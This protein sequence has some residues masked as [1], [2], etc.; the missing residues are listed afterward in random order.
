MKIALICPSN[1]LFMPYIKYYENTLNEN[2]MNYSIINWDRFHIEQD[3]ERFTYRDKKH[4][5]QRNL[6]D[7]YKYKTFVIQ[8]LKEFHFD[9]VIV[10]GLQLAFFLGK[11]LK[12]NFKGKYSIDIRD[13]NKI[14][15]YYKMEKLIKGSALTVISSPGFEQFLPANGQYTINHNTQVESLQEIAGSNACFQSEK[16]RIAC[17]GALRDYD[18]NIL[19]INTLKNNRKF[20]LFFHGEGRINPFIQDFIQK[21]EVENVVLTGRYEKEQEEELYMNSNMVNVFQFNTGIN[22]RTLLPNRLYHSAKYKKPLIA[23]EGSYLAEQIK[24][25]NLGLVIESFEGFEDKVTDY[26][27][28]FNQTEYEKGIYTFFENIISENNFFKCRLIEFCS[29]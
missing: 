4:G 6:Y 13:H 11:Y 23:L 15:D 8:K 2:G 25:Y 29:N 24:K 12:K 16:I 5:H 21:E 28:N 9:K 7:Y 10:F 20:E 3:S 19:L 27:V 17:I 26:V 18:V 14:V 22:N 1:R